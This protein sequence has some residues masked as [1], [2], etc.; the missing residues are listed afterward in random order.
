MHR[1]ITETSEKWGL[2]VYFVLI[3]RKKRRQKRE[4]S[5][6]A[7]RNWTREKETRGKVKILFG[8]DGGKMR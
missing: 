8:G 6:Q 3:N 7:T 5:M 4:N 2:F 1:K